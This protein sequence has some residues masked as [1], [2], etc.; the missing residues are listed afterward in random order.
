M[1]RTAW[2]SICESWDLRSYPS[3]FLSVAIQRK[4]GQQQGLISSTSKIF[5]LKNTVIIFIIFNDLSDGNLMTEDLNK[6]DEY[7]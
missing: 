5:I 4:R 2:L 1:T 3:K 6:R 7:F